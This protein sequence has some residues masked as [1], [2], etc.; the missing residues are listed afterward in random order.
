MNRAFLRITFLL[1]V[2]CSTAFAQQ[3]ADEQFDPP[4]PHP[5]YAPGKGLVVAI[6]EAHT[7]FHTLSGRFQAFAKLLAKDGYRLQA[8]TQ[9]FTASSLKPVNILVISNALHPANAQDWKLPT[10]SAFTTEEI[11]ALKAWIEGGGRL[12]LIADHMPMAGA[13]QDLGKALG[14][15]FSNGFAVEDGVQGPMF[16]RTSDRSLRDH[17]ILRGRSQPEAVSEVATFTGSAFRGEKL[18]PVFV[19]RKVTSLEPEVAWQFNEQTKKVP[20]EG[21]YQGATRRLGKGRIAVFGEAAMFT[22]QLAG[23]NKMPVGMNSP[24]AK[25]NP[26]FVLNVVHWLSGLLDEEKKTET[27]TLIG[28]WKGTSLCQARPGRCH[29]EVVVYHIKPSANV[30]HGYTL[31][32]DKV[33]NGELEDMGKLNC[34]FDPA[35]SVLECHYRPEDLWSF[36]LEGD[37]L[38]GTLVIPDNLL[39]RKVSVKR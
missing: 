5:A 7:N 28:D 30:K 19:F 36:K 26:Q 21:W 9:S 22:A 11:A 2:F 34:T 12:L 8:N 31:S 27:A 20:V 14:I 24:E 3:V 38:T 16:F 35:A 6:D 23:P 1:L 32:A 29:D 18:E 13:A 25:Q 37:K 4:I 15:E 10:P 17:A 33:I 39:L